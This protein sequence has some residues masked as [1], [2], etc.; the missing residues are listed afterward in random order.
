MKSRKVQAVSP[1]QHSI[2]SLA[3]APA[4]PSLSPDDV[5]AWRG[6]ANSGTNIIAFLKSIDQ[7]GLSGKT[8]PEFYQAVPPTTQATN[9]PDTTSPSSSPVL[10]DRISEFLKRVG[11]T[12]ESQTAHST[13]SRGGYLTLGISESPSAADACSLSDVLQPPEEVLPKYYLSVKALAGIYNRAVRRGKTLPPLL[14]ALLGE[15][16]Q[17]AGPRWTR[18]FVPRTAYHLT[19]SLQRWRHP[20]QAQRAPASAT[21]DTNS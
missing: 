19:M 17:E 2:F 13:T 4:S 6:K 20:G 5:R 16:V 9:S 10:P 7:L 21:P 8:S 15:A 1:D 11:A 12:A 3:E 18:T 14:A